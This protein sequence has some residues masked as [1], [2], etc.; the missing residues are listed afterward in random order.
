MSDSEFYTLLDKKHLGQIKATTSLR[1]IILSLSFQAAM[2]KLEALA[3][4]NVYL[5]KLVSIIA[6]KK[7]NWPW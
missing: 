6:T 5:T 4:T 1:K 2:E 3:N 7:L